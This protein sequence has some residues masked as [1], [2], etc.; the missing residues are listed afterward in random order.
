MEE[1][2]SARDPRETLRSIWRRLGDSTAISPIVALMYFPFGLA[3]PLW[4]DP[5][6]VG[7]SVSQWFVAGLVGQAGLTVTLLGGYRL[8]Y[9]RNPDAHHPVINLIVITL[10]VVARAI[11]IA[12]FAQAAEIV[13]EFE[14]QYRIGSGLAAQTGAL[15]FLSLLVS[16][17]AYHQR[18]IRDLAEQQSTL[19]ELNASMKVRLD[20]MQHEIKA[21]VRQSIDPLIAELNEALNKLT[22]STDMTQLQEYMRHVVDDELRPLSHRIVSAADREIEIPRSSIG[23]VETRVTWPQRTAL[24]VLIKPLMIGIWVGLLAGSQGLR[25]YSMP[26]AVFYAI[27][28]G[29]L[30]G[31]LLLV[32]RWAI[33]NWQPITW[34]GIF[35]TVA[36]TILSVVISYQLEKLSGIDV[37][38]QLGIAAFFAVPLMSL[39]TAF[40]SV[41]AVQRDSIEIQLKRSIDDRM[42]ALS[43]L[44]QR[45]YIARQHLGYVIHGTVQTSLNAA[46]MRLASTTVPD[47]QVVEA[48]RADIAKAVAKIDEPISPYVQL[49]DTLNDISSTWENTCD[50]RWSMDHKTVRILV[51]SPEAA[52]SVTEIVREGVGNAIRHGGATEVRI[53]IVGHSDRV[54]VSVI[55]NGSGVSHDSKP[56]LGSRMLDR[57]CFE[58]NRR[59]RDNETHLVAQIAT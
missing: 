14:I 38:E 31:G 29:L 28:S 8:V 1:F 54:V 27:L 22:K 48:V 47:M 20:E 41:I 35:V 46:A 19:D 51:D 44:K 26:Y 15:A 42:V 24:T 2:K 33:G 34:I 40:Y 18:L 59:S 12:W 58:W 56:G 43:L 6:R 5:G 37:P 50:I 16:T 10:A 49:V 30:V 9:S 13:D 45:E 52:V 53:R 36:V 23:S 39:M 17:Y 32:I 7:G 25:L 4:I 3:G 55:D 21:Q 11:S 57:T